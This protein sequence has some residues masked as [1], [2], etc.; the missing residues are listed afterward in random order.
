[1]SWEPWTREDWEHYGIR[2]EGWPAEEEAI[3]Q[4]CNFLISALYEPGEKGEV[5]DKDRIEKLIGEDPGPVNWGDL[6]CYD[7]EKRGEL[8]VARVSEAAPDATGLKRYLET[9]LQKWGWPVVV[10]TDW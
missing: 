7:V 2:P 9:W 3:R 8:H 5:V 6:K 4:S 1:M 10:E